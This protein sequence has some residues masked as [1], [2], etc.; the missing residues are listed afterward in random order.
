[1]FIFLYLL[2]FLFLQYIKF[3]LT[4]NPDFDLFLIHQFIRNIYQ[5]LKE[6]WIHYE[7]NNCLTHVLS[8]ISSVSIWNWWCASKSESIHVD[9]IMDIRLL[10]DR[11]YRWAWLH[12][13]S[14]YFS[15]FLFRGLKTFARSL[16]QWL[17]RSLVIINRS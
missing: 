1:M 14:G 13:I 16:S 4:F 3:Q 11:V 12:W 5:F 2:A 6:L 9:G 15:F 8:F 17:I 7:F 10:S